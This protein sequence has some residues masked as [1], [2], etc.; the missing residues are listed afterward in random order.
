[1]EKL[2]TKIFDGKE[3]EFLAIQSTRAMAKDL[4]IGFKENYYIRIEK[5][6]YQDNKKDK[7][8]VIWLRKKD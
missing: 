2:K 7:Y 3:Y 5:G 1:M 8:F 6:Y 4:A